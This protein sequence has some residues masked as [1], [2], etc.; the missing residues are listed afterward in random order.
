MPQLG[1][2]DKLPR[3]IKVY[4]W[5]LRLLKVPQAHRVTRGSKDIV[6][7]LIDLGYNHHKELDGHL[8]VNPKPTKGD[9]N[10]WNFEDDAPYLDDRGEFKD[11]FAYRHHQVFVAGEIANVAPLCPIMIL[12]VGY[13]R[14]PYCWCDAIR[15]A[16]D[17]GAKVLVIPH[18]YLAGQK[19]SGIPL[20]YQGVDFTYPYDLPQIRDVYEYAYRNGCLIFKGVADNR[21]RR[22]LFAQSA[23]YS[24]VG[25]GS[26]NHL[27]KPADICASSDYV[28]VSAP[29]GDRNVKDKKKMI[30]G[31]GA[32]NKYVTYDGGCMASGFAGSV[33]GLVWSRFP[34]LT[35]EQIREILRNTASN[36]RWDPY[37]GW[38][39]L[40]AYRAVSLK[41]SQLKGDVRFVRGSDKLVYRKGKKIL[42]IAVKNYGVF[43]VKRLA[44]VVFNGHPRKRVANKGN[45]I[46]PIVLKT[47]QIGHTICSIRGLSEVECEITLEGEIKDNRVWL[48]IFSLDVGGLNKVEVVSVKL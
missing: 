28:E 46:K 19:E 44:I 7:A 20:F 14:N 39:V 34:K 21:G 10:G 15:Y 38:G 41:E 26:A 22:V 31:Y 33:A 24:V 6:I 48:E 13:S 25:V 17:N 8:W 12:K 36:D 16:V 40:D 11:S 37:L 43:D 18:G 29:G 23:F 47:I 35:N 42:K 45:M 9:I 2:F 1:P 30:W 27:G 4:D 32:D 5:A 3:G